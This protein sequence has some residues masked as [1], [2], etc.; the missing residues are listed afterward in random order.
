[1]K[2][3]YELQQKDDHRSCYKQSFNTSGDIP[4]PAQH[5]IAIYK[6]DIKVL[7]LVVLSHLNLFSFKY[8]LVDYLIRTHL[9]NGQ[10]F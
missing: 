5:V 3:V 2:Q 7:I 1:M 8:E 10:S 6:L 9:D 4:S